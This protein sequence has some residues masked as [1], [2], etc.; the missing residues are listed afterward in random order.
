MCS[1]GLITVDGL[2]GHPRVER[3]ILKLGVAEQHLDHPDVSVLL[4]KMGGE[5]VP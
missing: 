4:Q 1:S 2:G 5:A 3:R